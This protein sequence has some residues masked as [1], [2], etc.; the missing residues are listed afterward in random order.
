MTRLIPMKVLGGRAGIRMVGV[1]W[2][3]ILFG[4]EELEGKVE[5]GEENEEGGGEEEESCVE[6]AHE[7]S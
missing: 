6:E 7:N 1:G 2:I 3:D 5:E 4:L